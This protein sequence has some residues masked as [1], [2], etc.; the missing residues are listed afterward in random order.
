MKE[1][2]LSLHLKEG[3]DVVMLTSHLGQPEDSTSH[4][5]RIVHGFWKLTDL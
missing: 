2:V 5:C 3:G 4:Y 1:N